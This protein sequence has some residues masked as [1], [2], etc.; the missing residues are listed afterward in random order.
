MSTEETPFRILSV[1]E[2]RALPAEQ[3]A[4]YL[5]RLAAHD[6][7]EEAGKE[8]APGPA[9][10]NERKAY[11]SGALAGLAVVA[12]AWLAIYIGYV[13]LRRSLGDDVATGISALAGLLAA[14]LYFVVRNRYVSRERERSQVEA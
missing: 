9:L 14:R 6:L 4:D 8:Q 2:L 3:Q 12:C 10:G 13:F 5:G 1:R 7:K 11:R